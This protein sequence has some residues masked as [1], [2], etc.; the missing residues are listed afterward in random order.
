[1]R[2][3]ERVILCIAWRYSTHRRDDMS[4]DVFKTKRWFTF[5]PFDYPAS[6]RREIK[7]IL[8]MCY[9]KQNTLEDYRQLKINTI[10]AHFESN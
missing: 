8:C 6:F 4:K 10:M 3:V 2:D 7:T 5:L 9:Y 1:M